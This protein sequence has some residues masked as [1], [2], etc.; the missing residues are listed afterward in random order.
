[1]SN[2]RMYMLNVNLSRYFSYYNRKSALKDSPLSHSDRESLLQF[3]FRY[4][5]EVA[6]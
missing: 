3:C 1:M 2:N 4:C 6:Q 5:C